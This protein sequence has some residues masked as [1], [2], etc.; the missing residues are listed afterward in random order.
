MPPDPDYAPCGNRERRE[1]RPCVNCRLPCRMLYPDDD[2][3]FP[4][5]APCVRHGRVCD[6]CIRP[7]PFL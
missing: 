3:D 7:C 1:T 2:P 5:D 4:D 6:P